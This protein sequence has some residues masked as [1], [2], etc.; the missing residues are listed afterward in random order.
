MDKYKANRSTG[1][2]AVFITE[3]L[4]QLRVKMKDNVKSI[5]GVTNVFTTE[6]NIHCTK[7]NRHIVINSPDDLF[8]VVT[9]P[10]WNALN[11]DGLT[12]DSPEGGQTLYSNLDNTQSATQG[13]TLCDTSLADYDLLTVDNICS[14]NVVCSNCYKVLNVGA[15][16]EHDY[17]YS[18]I[19]ENHDLLSL[20]DL[21]FAVL[22]IC[23]LMNK[24][25]YIQTQE[26]IQN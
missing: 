2:K 14:D 8:N 21:K 17:T 25:K 9:Q 13:E 6:G 4:T 16:V 24:L 22:N 10:D 7:D 15:Q 11:L 1:R 12:Q 26:F 3:D 23:G 19:S 18:V 20:Y 5:E